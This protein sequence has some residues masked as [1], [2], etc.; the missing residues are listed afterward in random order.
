MRQC[1]QCLIT[2]VF[3]H[4]YFQTRNLLKVITHQLKTPA[5][6]FYPVIR[7]FDQYQVAR[8]L[9]EAF[10]QNGFVHG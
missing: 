5:S 2:V 3:Q 4:D 1:Q 9:N 6:L 8:Q 7:A 10:S